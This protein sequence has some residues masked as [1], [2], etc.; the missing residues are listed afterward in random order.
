MKKINMELTELEYWITQRKRKKIR[1]WQ[2]AKEIGCSIPLLSQ[3]E[4]GKINIAYSSQQIYKQI[5]NQ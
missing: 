3:F 2:I 1:L 4:N 5:I